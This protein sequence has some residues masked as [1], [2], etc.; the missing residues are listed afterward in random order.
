M[1]DV[2]V[3]QFKTEVINGD[4]ATNKTPY[5]FYEVWF[6]GKL[7]HKFNGYDKAWGTYKNPH[8]LLCEVLIFAEK[9]GSFKREIYVKGEAPWILQEEERDE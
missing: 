6:K 4:R 5:S 3:K 8:D 2:I 1:V 7:L 9:L